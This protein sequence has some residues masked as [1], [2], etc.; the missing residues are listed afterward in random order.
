M[1]AISRNFFTVC[2]QMRVFMHVF[3]QEHM[4]KSTIDFPHPNQPE[5]KAYSSPQINHGGLFGRVL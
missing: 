1:A 2:Y 3:Y 5:R 4:Y